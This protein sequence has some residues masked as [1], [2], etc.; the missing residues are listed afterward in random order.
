MSARGGP[1]GVKT[2]LIGVIL[3]FVAMMNAMLHW[4]GGFDLGTGSVVIFAAGISLYAI[5]AIR[6]GR[7]RQQ[8]TETDR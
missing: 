5:G 7:N 1:K 3:I 6:G 4:R 8:T 2:R